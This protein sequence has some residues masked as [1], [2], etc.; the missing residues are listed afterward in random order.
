MHFFLSFFSGGDWPIFFTQTIKE[1]PWFPQVWSATNGN[2][3][4]QN[5]AFVLGYKT[6][7]AFF[8]KVF[9]QIFYLQWSIT[10]KLIFFIPF[11]ML[12]IVSSYFLSRYFFKNRLFNA[13]SSVIFATNTY[14][15]LLVGGGQ[16]GVAISYAASPIVLLSLISLIEEADKKRLFIAGL[17]A[18]LLLCVDPR[19]FGITI[20]TA[21]IFLLF[22]F[23]YKKLIYVAISL[24]ASV[25]LNTFWI[26]PFVFSGTSGLS[27][28]YT[29][30]DIL[31]FLSFAKLENSLGLL[32]PN[33]PENIFGKVSFMKGEF[34]ILPLLA[35]AAFLFKT[36]KK[37]KILGLLAILG[38][39]LSKGVNLPFGQVYYFLSAYIPLFTMFRDAT[40]W[41]LVI[42]IAYSI[43]IPIALYNIAETVR[44]AKKL[45]IYRLQF[46]NKLR[47]FQHTRQI[48]VGLFLVFWL[49]SIRS[50]FLGQ[51]TG[52]FQPK[53]I[54]AEYTRLEKKLSAEKDFSRILWIPQQSRFGFFSNTHPPVASYDLITSHDPIPT[55]KY[56][57][58]KETET[59]VKESAIKYVILPY[60]S[61]GEIFLEDRKYSESVRGK[62]LSNL[63]KIPWLTQD[64]SF[65]N[66]GVFLVKN[67]NPRF[68]LQDSQPLNVSQVTTTK[69][70]G[71]IQKSNKA[72]FLIF[73]EQFDSRWVL[74][75]GG[76]DTPSKVYKKKFN[77]FEIPSGITHFTIEYTTQKWVEYGIYASL[78]TIGIVLGSIVKTEIK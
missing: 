10:E 77:S 27:D 72:Q 15:L 58:K 60:D 21:G 39:F 9:T 30:N 13:L 48:I 26:L 6:F 63:K 43:L 29:G 56:L 23:S 76:K 32:H 24:V 18:G 53:Q 68:S 3:Y 66:L 8:A 65:K 14:A 28:A 51:V 22:N 11:W 5:V 46:A 33:W 52:T 70:S 47:G 41:Y 31:Y 74:K 75:A 44:K 17:L 35:F 16:M 37:L 19:I 49:F 67:P 36:N 54:P 71:T 61:V 45:T 25:L 12:A 78:L 59:F 69:Y 62:F 64:T 34:L 7:F 40:K 20:C 73:S 42:V 1:L 50:L 4:G 2:G 55:F 57:Q 38:I